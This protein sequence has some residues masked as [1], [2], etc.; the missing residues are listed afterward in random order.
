MDFTDKLAVTAPS[1]STTTD[2][3]DVNVQRR[4]WLGKAVKTA[5]GAGVLSLVDPLL[6]ASAWA[7]GSDAPE[8]TEVKI[9]FIPL[10]DCASV[11]MASVLG[12]D[13]KHGV[14]IIP[15]PACAKNSSMGIWISP[16]YCTA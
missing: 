16:M 13:T 4:Q 11:V 9:G 14:K 6:R 8:K 1:A 10:T 3:Q 7:A 15:S 5:A 12:F 2:S